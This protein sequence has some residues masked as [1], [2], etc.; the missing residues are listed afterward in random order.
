MVQQDQQHLCSTQDAGL[1][2]T[3]H[4]GLKDP[5]L[6]QLRR[7]LQLQLRSESLAQELHMLW[8][9]KKEKK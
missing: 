4:S 3:Q 5:A 8:A 6:P 2:P 9:A 1:I 7:R